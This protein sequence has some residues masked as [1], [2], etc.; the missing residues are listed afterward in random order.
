MNLSVH[1]AVVGSRLPP[2][3]PLLRG[4]STIRCCAAIL[5]RSDDELRNFDIW[6]GLE[7]EM[8]NGDAEVSSSSITCSCEDSSVCVSVTVSALA[9]E[10]SQCNMRKGMRTACRQMEL[11][12]SY[13]SLDFF[14]TCIFCIFADVEDTGFV[15]FGFLEVS[16]LN[17]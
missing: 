5:Q 10:P 9:C 1:D 16:W 11:K 15:N 2:P 13:W 17:K 12:S 7:I 8:R 4:G 6:G 3:P 14:N